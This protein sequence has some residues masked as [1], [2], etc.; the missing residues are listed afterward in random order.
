MRFLSF[1][2]SDGSAVAV[3]VGTDLIDLSV[4][5]PHLP[6]RLDQLIALGVEGVQHIMR[7]VRG[8]GGAALLNPVGLR[9]LPSIPHPKKIL[10][11]GLNYVDH[12]AE[13]PYKE[14]PEYPVFFLRCCNSLVGHERPLIR[15]RV[16]AQLDYEGEVVA[17]IGRR[18]RYVPREHALEAVAGYSIFNDASIR[19][20]QFKS[21]QWTVGKNFDGTG[22]FGPEVVTA[23]EVAPGAKGLQL[24]TR[25]N[26]S[27]VQ[28]AN[29]S[30]MVFPIDVLISRLSEV[31]TLEPG[32]IV[33]TGT[34]AGVGFARTPQIW[35]KPGD[36]CE[37]EVEGIGLLRNTVSDEESGGGSH[38][39]R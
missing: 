14:V 33:V 7:V 35:M 13:S 9:Y 29:T 28:S 3:R 19:D 22:A 11:V 25:L 6:R 39:A 4:A 18:T 17:V 12:A 27:V 8:A 1:A 26:G 30:D 16:S 31:F 23:D 38:E 34:P 10:C 5:A 20:Y 24:T 2:K 32:D 36:V 15:P 21:T 37:V